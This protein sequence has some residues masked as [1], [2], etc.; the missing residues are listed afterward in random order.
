MREKLLIGLIF[1]LFSLSPDLFAQEK[2]DLIQLE[3]NIQLSI[4]SERLEALRLPLVDRECL[5]RK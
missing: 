2:P 1:M 4:S 3:K 5:S